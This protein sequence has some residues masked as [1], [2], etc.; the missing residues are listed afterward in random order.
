MSETLR[1]LNIQV[2]R[3][4]NPSIYQII[5]L[6]WMNANEEVIGVMV[7]GIWVMTFSNV[8]IT[9]EIGIMTVEASVSFWVT[10]VQ[11]SVG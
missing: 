5:D 7:I 11:Q 2:N 6:T 1:W 3:E 4:S 10:H 9:V 8:D